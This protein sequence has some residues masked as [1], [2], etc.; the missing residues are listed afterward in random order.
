MRKLLALG[1]VVCFVLGLG[2][3]PAIAQD[4]ML[5]NPRTP[6]GGAPVDPGYFLQIEKISKYGE[7]ALG[8]TTSQTFTTNYSYS[9]NGMLVVGGETMV[10]ENGNGAI[11]RTDFTGAGNV[12][13]TNQ[14]K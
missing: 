1:F 13:N 8:L 12:T 3:V 10:V 11:V 5:W 9:A 6:A 2:V 7:R 4:V 14:G